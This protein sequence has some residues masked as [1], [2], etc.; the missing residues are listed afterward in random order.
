M[1]IDVCPQVASY[2][3]HHQ[4]PLGDRI[5]GTRMPRV[6][7]EAA[8]EARAGLPRKVDDRDGLERPSPA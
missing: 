7:A 6:R 4:V 1:V 8:A 5:A 2:I 3:T